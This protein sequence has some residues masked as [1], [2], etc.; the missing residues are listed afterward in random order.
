MACLRRRVVRGEGPDRFRVDVLA[1][2]SDDEVPRFRKDF[3]HLA[4]AG[5]ALATIIWASQA[6]GRWRRGSTN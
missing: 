2:V 3:V 6:G 4:R 1:G 5:T